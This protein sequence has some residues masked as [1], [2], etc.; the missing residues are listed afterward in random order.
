MSTGTTRIMA[1]SVQCDGV[2]ANPARGADDP[3][4]VN[5]IA[6]QIRPLT[7]GVDD[8]ERVL[9][10]VEWAAREAALLDTPLRI[11]HA[12]VWPLLHLPPA[13]RR[14]GPPGG[15]R[16]YAE[17]LLRRA[18]DHAR[19]VAPNVAVTT[20]LVKDFPYPLLVEESRTSE[21]VVVGTSGMG[22]LASALAGSI[23]VQ[24]SVNAH[25]PTVLVRGVTRRADEPAGRVV[26]GVD[27]SELAMTAA[28][29]AGR[30][31]AY[32]GVPLM[33]VH[34][35]GRDS[36]ADDST[37][38]ATPLESGPLE[39][40]PLESALARVR[41]L[42]PSLDVENRLVSGHAAGA[43][44]EESREADL[45]VVGSRGR[46][47]FAGLLLGSVSQTLLH[48]AECPVMV[49]PPKAAERMAREEPAADASAAGEHSTAGE[50]RDQSGGRRTGGPT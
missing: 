22:P 30:E 15:E 44:V 48:Q 12:F 9:R 29:L 23:A 49:V 11:V 19:S 5:E 27:G 7:V 45:V 41:R 42:Y 26:V 20:A 34:V 14:M 3:R 17:K 16:V 13:V 2:R 4:T 25:A 46:G 50:E 10:A 35:A 21:Y 28:E 39:S 36:R 40:G 1:G 32:R 33:L 31:A 43:L 37:V 38:G 8:S 47:G 18:A 24:L 6:A